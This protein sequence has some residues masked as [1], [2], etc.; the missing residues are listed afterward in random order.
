VDDYYRYDG[1]KQKGCDRRPGGRQAAA[2]CAAVEAAVGDDKTLQHC[3]GLA[4][5]AAQD[6]GAA[7]QGGPAAA[8]AGAALGSRRVAAGGGGCGSGGGASSSDQ[9]LE[10]PAARDSFFQWRRYVVGYTTHLSNLQE[11]AFQVCG[12]VKRSGVGVS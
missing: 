5:G 4:A 3:F 9:G 10:A 11:H 7:R 1:G 8:G 12:L 2:A 6:G